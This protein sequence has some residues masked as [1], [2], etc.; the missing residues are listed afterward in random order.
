MVTSSSSLAVTIH[1]TTLQ[2]VIIFCKQ[3]CRQFFERKLIGGVS[4][5]TMF[6]VSLKSGSSLVI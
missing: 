3:T 6:I 5:L 1:M 4:S 2:Q